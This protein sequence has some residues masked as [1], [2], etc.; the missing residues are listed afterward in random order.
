[1]M[2]LL[3]L[4]WL[5]FNDFKMNHEPLTLRQKYLIKIKSIRIQGTRSIFGSWKRDIL[6]TCWLFLPSCSQLITANDAG[7]E[8]WECPDIFPL[9][10]HTSSARTLRLLPAPQVNKHSQT[11][12]RHFSWQTSFPTSAWWFCGYYQLLDPESVVFVLCVKFRL[13]NF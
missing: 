1:M 2:S 9:P 10:H 7:T 5:D 4:L 3:W 12:M 6:L 11:L 13:L 8:N